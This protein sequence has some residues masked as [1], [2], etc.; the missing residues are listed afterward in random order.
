M[1]ISVTFHL[2]AAVIW[3]GG[4]FFAHGMLRPVAASLLEPPLRLQLWVQVFRRFF[5]WVWISIA[6]LLATGYSMVFMVFD[7]FSNT[8]V[9]VHIMHLLGLIMVAIFLFVYFRSYQGLKRE[10]SASNFP[11]AAEHL[12][13]I[14]RLVGI[15]IILGLSTIIVASAGRYY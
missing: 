3:V 2:L 15:N 9:Y 4:M 13:T 5:V 14:R 7:G 11:A 1:S 12:A 6:I 10:V 8:G